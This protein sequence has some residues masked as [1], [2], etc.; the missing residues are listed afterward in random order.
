M[1]SGNEIFIYKEQGSAYGFAMP[2]NLDRSVADHPKS[3]VI[4]FVEIDR[5]DVGNVL[6]H[7]SQV[8]QGHEGYVVYATVDGSINV[9]T[10]QFVV[11]QL[12]I[13]LGE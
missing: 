13:Q 2:P 12:R 8:S 6:I 11:N 7:S 5:Q 9:G 4:M 10:R 3:E 1:V